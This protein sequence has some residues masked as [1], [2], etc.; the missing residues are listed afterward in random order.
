MVKLSISYSLNFT[1]P[2]AVL[3]QLSRMWVTRTPLLFRYSIVLTV[4]AVPEQPV[5]IKKKIST[6]PERAVVDQHF[7]PS[8]S[9]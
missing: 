2:Q 5:S 8:Q 3:Y 9:L 4:S 1:A 7:A 6:G